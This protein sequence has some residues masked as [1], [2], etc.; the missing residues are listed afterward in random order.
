MN[1]KKMATAS[2]LSMGLIGSLFTTTTF[3]YEPSDQVETVAH[4]G[5]SGYAPENT[6]AAFQKGVDMKADYIEIDVQQTKDGEL[7]VIHD[8]TLDRTTDGTGYVKD[9]TLEEIRQLDAGSYFGPE[10][11]GEKVPTFEEVL[12][13]FR[14]KTGILIELKATY[15]YPGIEQKVA[16]AL[17]ERN[18][19]LPSNEKIIVQSFEFESMKKMDELLPSVPVGLLTSRATDLSEEKLNEFASY[20]EYVNP[21]KS[22]VNSS[23]VNEVH[24][25]NMGIMAW[26]VRKQEEVQPLLD[27]G[28]DGIITD[29]PDYPPL[30][31]AN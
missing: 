16:E 14:G 3:A 12:D 17:L 11:A 8:V 31:K 22:L 9:H 26:T 10:F 4:R 24:E 28:V 29:Y 19:H 25:R 13:E 5:A 23:L 30:H 1:V 21:S 2:L 15:Y 6:M 20:A 18:M 7:V 27:A